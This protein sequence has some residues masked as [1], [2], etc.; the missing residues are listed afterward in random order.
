MHFRSVTPSR[1]VSWLWTRGPNAPKMLLRHALVTKFRGL[2]SPGVG[3]EDSE[4]HELRRWGLVLLRA[5]WEGA[6]DGVTSPV[7]AP[8]YGAAI[9]A[10]GARAKR[11]RRVRHG[12]KVSR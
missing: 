2:S 6:P 4:L 7:D 1:P 8:C 12:L 5:F 10:L 9:H 11:S 3:T